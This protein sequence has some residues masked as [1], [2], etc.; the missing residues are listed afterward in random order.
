MISL[1]RELFLDITSF[2]KSSRTLK[3]EFGYWGEALDKWYEQG[4]PNFKGLS[5]LTSFG[6]YGPAFPTPSYGL[7]DFIPEDYDVSKYFNF[8]EG[9]TSVP[10]NYW[11]CPLMDVKVVYEDDKYIEQYGPDGIR[12]RQLKDGSSMPLWLEFPVKNRKDWEKIKKERFS[13]DNIDKRFAPHFNDFIKKA[14]KRTYPLGIFNYPCGFFGSLRQLIGAEG[15]FVMYY[16]DPHLIKD[17]AN[18][19]CSLWISIGEELTAKIDFDLTFFWEDMCGKNGS[20]ISTSTFKEFMSSYYKRIVDFLK[21]KGID[22]FVVD[23]DGNVEELIP[24]FLEAG[25][26]MMYP[27]ER[28]AGNEL[29]KYRKDYPELVMLGGIDKNTL[30]KGK[31]AIDEEL[32]NIAW[33]ISQGGYIPYADHVIPPNVPW[34]NFKYY[35]NKLNK[36]IDSTKVM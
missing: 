21:S 7:A 9:F 30:Y 6:A 15:L 36:I 32:E 17:I 1:S 26:K 18:H 29:V 4:L 10:V 2:K 28:Q 20:F 14:K 12:T 13:L 3:W 23:T 27:F 25:V 19:L 34:E 8:D 16:D 5:G 22:K 33:M 11:T 24:L 35:R 31:K